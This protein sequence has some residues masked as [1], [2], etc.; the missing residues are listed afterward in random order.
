MS[1]FGIVL[2]APTIVVPCG[3]DGYLG[4]Y[5]SESAKLTLTLLSEDDPN[6]QKTN[7]FS[8]QRAPGVV[9]RLRWIRYMSLLINL[10]LSAGMALLLKAVR[11]L[12]R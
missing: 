7:C 1:W 11:V 3:E 10:G 12:S 8:K 9:D 6:P 5:Q 2:S 4:R